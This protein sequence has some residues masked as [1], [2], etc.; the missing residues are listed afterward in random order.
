M[1]PARDWSMGSKLAVGG[2]AVLTAGALAY[3]A[4]KYLPSRGYKGGKLFASIAGTAGAV[5][6]GAY[7]LLHQ[8]QLL[9]G[10]TALA[11][12]PADSVSQALPGDTLERIAWARPQVVM[13]HTTPAALSRGAPEVF[14]AVRGVVPDVRLWLAAGC[15]GLTRWLG[16]EP[17][18]ATFREVLR[19]L[20]ELARVAVALGAEAV[21][22]D[23]EAAAKEYPDAGRLFARAAREVFA[24]RAP[25]VVQGHTAYDQPGQHA[26]YDWAA[27]MGPNAPQVRFALPEVYV[28]PED[29][30]TAPPG[31]LGRRLERHNASWSAAVRAGWIRA[32]VVRWPYV[33]A[34]G[35][36]A[37]DTIT[38]CAPFHLRALW[39]APRTIDPDGWLACAALSSLYRAGFVGPTAL[40]SF[41]RAHG[42]VAD[43]V[44]GSAVQHALIEG[45]RGRPAISLTG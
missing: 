39:T 24:L 42:L 4:A 5:G 7:G 16:T 2:G 9:R 12:Y 40:V 10:G 8:N 27:W 30:G 36:R 28:A 14:A 23:Q 41:Q 34:H 43:G 3:L 13:L 38:V 11:L 1:I 22:W 20:A 44:A 25:G 18:E 32:D 35:V 31:A 26:S 29:G 45:E 33:Q 21:V 15:D 17:T 37:E 19:Q 6:L